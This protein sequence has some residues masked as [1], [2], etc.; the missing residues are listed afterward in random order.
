MNS[1]RYFCR[2][3]IKNLAPYV[4]GYQPENPDQVIK[5]NANENPYPPSPQVL[6]AL[7]SHISGDLRLYPNS[8]S[9]SL[10][11]Q[12]AQV[13][14][15]KENQVF[16]ANGSDETISLIFRT[17]ADA[18]DLIVSPYPTY[19]V[20]QTAAEIHEMEYRSIETDPAFQIDLQDFLSVNAKLAFIANPNAQTGLLLTRR[21]IDGFLT[22]F[23]G[24]L[25]LDETYIDFTG[26][27]ESAYSLVRDYDNLLVLR[28]FSKSFSLCGIRV[29]Y[30]FGHPQLIEALD[31]TKDS[32]NIAYLN[33]IAAVEALKDIDYMQKNA[34]RIADN[35]QRF[36]QALINLS[37]EVIP[38]AG[39]FVL[40][41]HPRLAAQEIYQALK[42]RNILVRWFDQRRLQDYIRISI[43]TDEQL[44]ALL[45]ALQEIV[46]C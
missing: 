44:E 9:S 17:F 29:G 43:G 46:N 24:L 22:S 26:G 6:E 12:L 30:A 45:S 20:Y 21:N 19:T 32:Y 35:R 13:Y 18:G 34:D 25:V 11:R 31:K 38:S 2:A 23:D 5:L 42:A 27:A 16:A 39:N 36:I 1:S 8:R 7:R 41:R 15:M 14:Q 40:T 37:F 33:Q 10:R 28:T 4:P 3:N